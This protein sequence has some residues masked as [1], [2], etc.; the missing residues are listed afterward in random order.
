M[1]ILIVVVVVLLLLLVVGKRPSQVA[2]NGSS[3]AISL[4][5]VPT[6]R[7]VTVSPGTASFGN[8]SGGSAGADTASTTNAL[9]FPNGRCWLGSPGAAGSFP[10]TITYN[11]PP[12]KVYVSGSSADPSDGGNSWNLCNQATA[13]TGPGGLPG[14]DQYMAKTFGSGRN[15][16][17]GLS[18]NLSCDE[19]FGPAGCT[20]SEGQT[21]REGVELIGPQSSS[22]TS[23]SW[24]VTITW[25]A[26]PVGS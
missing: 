11:G 20:A 4:K 25:A 17:T 15:N 3:V 26:G 23:G 22:S 18:D 10:I 7:S 8:C 2:A 1:W 13:C 16:S 24:T 9:G 5:T 14:A 6:I 19:E 21:Q 12:G